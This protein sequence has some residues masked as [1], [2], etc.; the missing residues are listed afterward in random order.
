MQLKYSILKQPTYR[1]FPYTIMF[2]L[3]PF[4][5][6]YFKTFYKFKCIDYNKSYHCHNHQAQ[7]Y[8]NKTDRLIDIY[9]LDDNNCFGYFSDIQEKLICQNGYLLRRAHADHIVRIHELGIVI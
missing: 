2:E 7:L 5:F 3:V 4:K 8:E 6:E 9:L 1:C